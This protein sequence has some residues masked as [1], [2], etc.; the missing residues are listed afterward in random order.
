M[1]LPHL[2][3]IGGEKRIFLKIKQKKFGL[4]WWWPVVRGKHMLSNQFITCNTSLFN[5]TL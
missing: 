5:I 1:F 4:C 3:Y 2:K